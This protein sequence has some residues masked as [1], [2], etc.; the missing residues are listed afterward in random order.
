MILENHAT[1]T[2]TGWIAV[3]SLSE[4]QQKARV[5]FREGKSQIVVFISNQHV[6]A[7]DNRCPHE[8]YPLSQG[9]LDTEQCTLTCQWH[10]WKFDLKSGLATVGQ[11]SVRTYPSRILE[12]QVWVDLSPPSEAELAAALIKSVNIAFEKRQYGRMARELARFHYAGLDPLLALQQVILWSYQCLEFGMGHAYAAAADWVSLYRQAKDPVSQL[13][14]LNEAIDHIAQESLRQPL[15]EYS[16]SGAQEHTLVEAI[17]KEDHSTAYQRVHEALNPPASNDQPLDY[18][19]A[20]AALAHYNDFGHSL[21]YLV[22]SLEL[23]ETLG[24]SVREALL[25]SLTRSMIYATREDLLPEFKDYAPT[26]ERLETQIASGWGQDTA[27]PEIS[28]LTGA[29]VK[30]ALNWV[31]TQAQQHTPRAIYQALLAANAHNLLYFDTQFETA[32]DNPLSENIGWLDFTHAL[33]FANAVR[34]TCQKHPDLWPQG[35]LQIAAF[36]G[37][38]TAYLDL[39]QPF[40]HEA[41]EAFDWLA[42]LD[43]LLDHGLGLPIFASHLVKTAVA[44]ASEIENL[45]SAAIDPNPSHQLLTLALQRFLGASIKQ[46]HLRRVMKQSLLLVSKDF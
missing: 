31:T 10:N 2:Q 20:Q 4:L 15:F 32:N 37:R 8:G 26:L 42:I 43:R 19:L 6:Y 27:P 30:Q 24:E 23:I 16:Q 44:V 45:Q 35:L 11:D 41:A 1:D 7:I 13:S 3:C 17:E 46:R 12:A 29:S 9:A 38:N 18:L 25:L 34:I 21:I 22:K 14:A 40:M 5:V 28:T 39:Q 36:Y 33:T